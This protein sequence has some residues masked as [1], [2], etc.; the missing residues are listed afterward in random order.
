[1]AKL[2]PIG[3]DLLRK[4]SEVGLAVVKELEFENDKVALVVLR[5]PDGALQCH[6]YFFSGKEWMVWFDVLPHNS[7]LGNVIDWVFDRG[8][9]EGALARDKDLDV[10]AG[11]Q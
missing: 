9:C 6:R 11:V 3:L 10:T 5:Y 1:M 7:S 8:M 4:H 2:N